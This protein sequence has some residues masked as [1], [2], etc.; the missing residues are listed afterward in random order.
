MYGVGAESWLYRQKLATMHDSKVWELVSVFPLSAIAIDG[1][2]TYGTSPAHPS[3]VFKIDCRVFDSPNGKLHG[4]L[5]V[6]TGPVKS[7]S[8]FG[9]SIFAIMEN[10]KIYN[11]SLAA[12]NLPSNATEL[13]SFEDFWTLK[14]SANMLSIAVVGDTIYGVSQT[15]KVCRVPVVVNEKWAPIAAG[16]M[17]S[18]AF[19]ANGDTIYAAGEDGNVYKQ[20]LLTMSLG[21]EWIQVASPDVSSIAIQGGTIYGVSSDRRVYKQRLNSLSSEIPWERASACCVLQVAI[22]DGIVYAVGEDSKVYS[23]NDILMTPSSQWV[24]VADG[25]WKY[26]TTRED[27]MYGVD[28]Y[29]ITYI[30]SLSYLTPY[31][32]WTRTSIEDEDQNY[33]AKAYTCI[34]AHNDVMYACG[35]DMVIYSKFIDRHIS[36]PPRLRAR[37]NTYDQAFE[38]NLTDLRKYPSLATAHVETTPPFAATTTLKRE[39][40]DL[41]GSSTTTLQIYQDGQE[42]GLSKMYVDAYRDKNSSAIY[43]NAL[44][45]AELNALSFVACSLAVLFQP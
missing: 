19:S 28:P 30:Q 15:Y 18:L 45:G 29:G 32:R 40:Q 1:N 10:S 35:Q 22:A 6:T 17:Q 7:F 20:D 26:I 42:P 36:Y 12:Q 24:L 41:S 37:G 39:V 31:K 21:T 5:L 8:V 14:N 27:S 3:E 23:Q 25:P 11:K 34:T 13:P 4:W 2:T 33:P 16:R 38:K 44:H 43:G 9:D